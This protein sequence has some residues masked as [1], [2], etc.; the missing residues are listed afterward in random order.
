MSETN[1]LMPTSIMPESTKVQSVNRKHKLTDAEAGA[2]QALLGLQCLQFPATEKEESPRKKTKR[3]H[4]PH[5]GGAPRKNDLK[6]DKLVIQCD[7]FGNPWFFLTMFYL[8]RIAWVKKTIV[9][10]GKSKGTD[11]TV[12]PLPD[13]KDTDDNP[14]KHPIFK[15]Y[16]LTVPTRIFHSI[17]GKMPAPEDTL[18]PKRH[19]AISQ[20]WNML[21]FSVKTSKEGDMVTLTYCQATYKSNG[22]RMDRDSGKTTPDI[23]FVQSSASTSP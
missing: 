2:I 21:G 6:R 14:Q 20:M 4:E 5:A 3:D 9:D 16:A 8:N 23:T 11:V 22:W 13:K 10:E 12:H 15:A 1:G 7:K 18:S 17:V 19:K